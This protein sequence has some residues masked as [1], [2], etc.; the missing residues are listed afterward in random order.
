MKNKT[1]MMSAMVLAA[2]ICFISGCEQPD[3]SLRYQALVDGYIEAWNTG[4]FENLERIVSSDF[5]FRLTPKFEALVGLDSLKAE[6]GLYRTAYSDFKIDLLETVYSEN[7]AA[8]RWKITGTHTG[9]GW[10]PPTGKQLDVMGMSLVH[11]EEG[12]MKDEWVAG[13]NLLWMQQ[14]GFTLIPPEP[15]N[16]GKETP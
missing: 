2:G 5:E 7:A 1:I 15:G 3:P 13:N 9:S 14:L 12:K 11:F 10:I 16:E 4:N 8:V 6:I